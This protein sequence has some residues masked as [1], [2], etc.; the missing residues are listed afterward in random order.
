[1]FNKDE[2][3]ENLLAF[4]KRPGYQAMDEADLLEVLFVPAPHANEARLII[5]E[6]ETAGLLLR[7]KK[8]KL[9]P[10]EQKNVLQARLQ[11]NR[12]GFAFAILEQEGMPDVFIPEENMN[13]AMHGDIVL[14]RVLDAG[15]KGRK[16]EGEVYRI[17]QHANKT[18]VGIYKA[19]SGY[20]VFIPDEM[21]ISGSFRVELD[22]KQTPPDGSKVV[23]EV[24]DWGTAVKAPSVK[25]IEMIGMMGDPGVDVL[26]IIRKFQF[27]DRFPAQ[28]IAAAEK[29]PTQVQ[30]HDIIGRED[31]REKLI[32]TIDGADAKDLDDAISVEKDNNGN[33]V[34][35]VH[36]ADVSHYVA[37]GGEIEKEAYKRATSVYLVDRV[38]PM[39]PE[40]L[41][42]GVCSLNPQVDRLTLSAFMVLSP[43]GD[44]L[45]HRFARS[46]INSKHRMVYTEVNEVLEA[47]ED[48]IPEA[49]LAYKPHYSLIKDMA[50]LADVLSKKRTKRGS[51]DFNFPET[52]VKLDELGKAVDVYRVIRGKA[53]SMIEQFMI[54]ANETVAKHLNLI[55]SPGI[56]RV[57]EKPNDE[58]MMKLARFLSPFGLVLKGWQNVHPK[59]LQ[60]VL[61][62]A[63]ELP[64]ASMIST[65]MLRSLTRAR[66]AGANLGHF[67]LA[68]EYYTHFTSPIRRYPDLIIHRLL[69]TF[70]V[71]AHDRHLPADMSHIA[72][73]IALASVQSSEREREADDAERESMD[74][75]IA[76]FMHSKIGEAYTGEV[77]GVTNFGIFVMLENG[78]E[79]LVPIESLGDD[80][81]VFD[82]SSMT[83]RG[84]RTHRE[85][86]IGDKVDIVVVSA[87]AE[88]RRVEF[89]VPDAVRG[90]GKGK[91]TPRAAKVEP[92]RKKKTES[93]AALPP[94][95]KKGGKTA[96]PARKAGKAGKNGGKKGGRGKKRK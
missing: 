37:W 47:G 52:K 55:G 21:R 43:E 8:G 29:I 80:Y 64:N 13:G 1:M 87:D 57:H 53:E 40:R 20:A 70:V 81:Y 67:G 73:Y 59:A 41:S 3:L 15:G 6:L 33:W 54:E 45:D 83:L 24:V 61:D 66:Y 68:A 11:G 2:F 16:T 95:K 5:A 78:A 92:S 85:F 65:V 96:G 82:E 50:E 76:E 19:F 74:M 12:K 63:K 27:P 18:M 77:T 48:N 69:K 60:K 26:S 72:E 10:P 34:L 51:I 4:V 9:Y 44:V 75:K 14:V 30:E 28:V 84:E 46:V 39:L 36:I 90:M 49:L 88:T 17:L 32:V 23:V 35:G 22:P 62:D 71:T 86:T 42:N 58:S 56:Y 93:T 94:W 89:M 91:T 7:S 38:I 79:G 31:L 25:V